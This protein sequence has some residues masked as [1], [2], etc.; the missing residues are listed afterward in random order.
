VI[1]SPFFGRFLFLVI[2]SNPVCIVDKE[3]NIVVLPC[4]LNNFRISTSYFDIKS[5]PGQL[6]CMLDLYVGD[7]GIQASVFLGF[8]FLWITVG[9]LMLYILA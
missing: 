7:R 8:E 5:A 6:G 3:N 2:T 9:L 1:A 4:E